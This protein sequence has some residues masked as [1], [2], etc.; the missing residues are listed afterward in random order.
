M[1]PCELNVPTDLLDSVFPFDDFLCDE[2]CESSSA[3]TAPTTFSPSI[4]GQYQLNGASLFDTEYVDPAMLKGPDT[5]AMGNSIN[6]YTF[7]AMQYTQNESSPYN[8]EW[9]SPAADFEQ[10]Q[11][12]FQA[13]QDFSSAGVGFANA[14]D[15]SA[16]G[17]ASFDWPEAQQGFHGATG[18]L[19]SSQR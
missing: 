7:P 8:S 15:T 12:L 1:D 6:D 17:D 5:T 18:N 2:P 4:G 14:P 10:Q 11:K 16:Q 13:Q 3:S 19:A 9:Q